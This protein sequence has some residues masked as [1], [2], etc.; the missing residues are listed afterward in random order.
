MI[1]AW[2]GSVLNVMTGIASY[3]RPTTAQVVKPAA[4]PW[5]LQTVTLALA[6]LLVAGVLQRGTAALAPSGAVL[7]LTAVPTLLA[8]LFLFGNL[9]QRGQLRA[10]V[11]SW[12][13]V[14][15]FLAGV[16]W[17]GLG[18][19][20][21]WQPVAL[22]SLVG[23]GILVVSQRLA[24]VVAASMR[25]LG[26]GAVAA[27]DSAAWMVAG[28][29]WLAASTPL[30]LGPVADLGA[31]QEPSMPTVILACSPLSHLAV[32]AGHD[33]LRGEWFYG[34]SSLGS[35]QADYPRIGAILVAYVMLASLLTLLLA[36]LR[37][38]SEQAGRRAAAA[39]A[40]P[41]A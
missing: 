28:L 13:L 22:A 10:S 5:P 11:L 14:V 19:R 27:A 4:T 36:P 21:A 39:A 15:A 23:L 18:A 29:L 20:L 7:M 2:R 17:I 30:W 12:A 16:A 35:L 38:W 25:S 3:D 8:P 40:G 37:R 1:R 6:A 26:V 41:G 9:D 34:H 31:R 32:A 33:F 24:S